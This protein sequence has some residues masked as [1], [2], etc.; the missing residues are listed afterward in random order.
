MHGW[1]DPT[2]T[3]DVLRHGV[4]PGI[5]AVIGFLFPLDVRQQFAQALTARR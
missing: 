1:L 2:L 3:A 5:L 4:I